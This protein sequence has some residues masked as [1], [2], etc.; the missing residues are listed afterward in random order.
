LPTLTL[1]TV[2]LSDCLRLF[3]G[4]EVVVAITLCESLPLVRTYSQKHNT[5]A[6]GIQALFAYGISSVVCLL[7]VLVFGPLQAVIIAF[8]MPTIDLLRRTSRPETWVLLEAPDG[9]HFIPEEAEHAPDH[10]PDTTGIIIYRFGAPLYFANATLFGEEVEKLVMQAANPIKWL[11]LDAEA[12]VD[13]DITGE[14][15][16]HQVLTL[17]AERG[18]TVA[19][20]RANQSIAALL[21]RYHLLELIGKNRLYPA[22]RLAIAAFR[23]ET[24]QATPERFRS[25]MRL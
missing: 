12:I 16:L 5:R 3:P 7:S 15:A 1:T 11:V 9:S 23:R 10:T 17:L 6:D 8:L 25:E 24:G 14:A 19:V 22:N 4:A 21:S 2:P 18:V 20:S 13:I